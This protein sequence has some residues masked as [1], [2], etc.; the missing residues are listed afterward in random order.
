MGMSG[1]DS[2]PGLEASAISGLFETWSDGGLWADVN[3]L[4]DR[5][6]ASEKDD[7]L[8][9]WHHL[10]MAVGNFKRQRG[11]RLQPPLLAPR[12]DVQ[13]R[14]L[15]GAFVL[16][17]SEPVVVIEVDDPASWSLLEKRLPGAAVAT[18]TTLLAALWPERHFVFDWRVRAAANGLRVL[19]GLETTAGV[20]PEGSK[21]P[22]LT[23]DD[24]CIVR[25]WILDA[26][27]RTGEPL[28]AIERALYR[29]SQKASKAKRKAEGRGKAAQTW[30]EYADEIAS[31]VAAL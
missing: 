17:E 9:A 7:R 4:A 25:D 29:L 27:E 15:S 14:R 12:L 6:W 28:V 23:L 13:P 3:W 21:S 8:V 16:P 11:R 30:S 31:V 1:G 18:V 19:S 22:K 2:L 26:A 5:F 20:E 24:Y 10:V